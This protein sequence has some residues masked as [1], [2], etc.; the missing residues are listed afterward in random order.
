M[1]YAISGKLKS[2]KDLVGKI[3]QYLTSPEHVR[4]EIPDILDW[5]K[6]DVCR[7]CVSPFQIKKF[8]DILKDIVCMLVGCTREQLEDQDFKN[9]ELGEEWWYWKPIEEDTGYLIPYEQP[10]GTL[11]YKLVKHTP[12]TL[13]QLLGTEAGRNIIHPNIWCTSLFAGYK[14]YEE[15]KQFNN[16]TPKDK[17]YPNW[18]ITDCRFSNEMKAVKDR[19]GITIRINRPIHL[20][21]P[22][23]WIDFLS[24]QPSKTEEADFLEWLQNHKE[25]T[26]Q[27]L[28]ITL[29]HKSE[30]EL[31]TGTF[32]YVINNDGG[33]EA[34]V[35]QIKQFIK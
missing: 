27:E 28:Y 10:T 33:I 35:E 32:D 29:T 19:G 11:P 13:L 30:T 7:E 2:G 24:S 26:H 25:K 9:T 23:F 17:E 16:K 18:I 20:R 31:D 22:E 14:T 3:I 8:A 12:R 34:L 21:F 5:I 15:T 1:I 4:L 6:D